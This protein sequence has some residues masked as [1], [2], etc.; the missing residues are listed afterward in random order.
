MNTRYALLGAMLALT[1]A[2]FADVDW[3]VLP[4]YSRSGRMLVHGTRDA[5]F[6]DGKPVRIVPSVRLHTPD[7]ENK[8]KYKF[9]RM[10]IIS[11]L[12]EKGLAVIWTNG[13]PT[14]DRNPAKT[15]GVLE[16]RAAAVAMLRSCATA[17]EAAAYMRKAFDKK[18]VSGSAIFFV[19]DPNHAQV[20]EC[21]PR[22]FASWELARPFCIYSNSWKLPGMDDG[23]ANPIG[24]AT[25]YYER[26]WV[27]RE[28]LRTSFD[29]RGSVSV[30]DSIRASRVNAAEAN[31]EAFA[32]R[33]GPAKV[34][35]AA[36]NRNSADSYLFELDSEYPGELS[37]VYAALGPQRHTVYLPI[38]MG[39]ADKLPEALSGEEWSGQAVRLHAAASPEDPVR[40]E[41]V[42]FER[43]QLADFAGAREEARYLL[44]RDRCEEARQLLRETLARQTKETL[45]FLTKLK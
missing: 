11:G 6:R 37:C 35:A 41:L 40:P 18:R 4:R 17:K 12:N 14:H 13:D 23:S 8:A 9:L 38:P 10:S 30:A 19:A 33:R 43:R 16:P 42:E 21:S 2:A 45:E 1:T 36:F 24:R 15:A 20:I 39:A 34:T 31:G 5:A 29:E 44:Q 28:A 3:M 26:E 25:T 7:P 32:K 27:V 22:H